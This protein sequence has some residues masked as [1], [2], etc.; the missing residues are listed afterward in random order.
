VL[1]RQHGRGTPRAPRPRQCLAPLVGLL[2]CLLLSPFSP[3]PSW[4]TAE[5]RRELQRGAKNAVERQHSREQQSKLSFR[6]FLPRQRSIPRRSPLS[7]LSYIRA[8]CVV[9][10][11]VS[12]DNTASS[13]CVDD[14][15]GR[16]HG[17]VPL[18]CARA[19]Y[20]SWLLLK[21]SGNSLPKGM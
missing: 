5:F 18:V 21:N 12:S 20:Y 6:S 14:F 3:S 9:E 16:Q 7:L 4:R 11:N 19:H 13:E 10:C 15:S 17:L 2:V 8:R 1:S